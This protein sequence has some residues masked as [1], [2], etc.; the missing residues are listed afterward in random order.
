MPK[1]IKIAITI[2]ILGIVYSLCK[3]VYTSFTGFYNQTVGY[4][5]QNT[6][7]EQG[8]VTSFDNYYLVFQQKSNITTMSKDV[9]VEITKIIMTNRKDGQNLSWK[10]VQENQQIP[11]TEFTCFYKELSA[12]ITEQYAVNSKIEL[13]K[14]QV[15]KE[16][17]TLIKTFP[18]V[19]YNYFIGVEP[20]VYKEGFISEQSKKLFNK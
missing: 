13:Q 10:W 7:L 14:Q 19:I 15:V 18:G 16:H 9:F 8:Q 17:N 5:M 1:S 2:L 12:F 4:S 6:A 11:Y 3:N 20:L